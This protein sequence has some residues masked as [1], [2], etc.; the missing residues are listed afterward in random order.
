MATTEQVYV[1][2]IECAAC[3]KRFDP[4]RPKFPAAADGWVAWRPA[5]AAQFQPA[6]Y[7]S[8]ECATDHGLYY[9]GDLDLEG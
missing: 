9:T 3:G 5:D 2:T 6:N 7:C 4:D 8:D 1:H